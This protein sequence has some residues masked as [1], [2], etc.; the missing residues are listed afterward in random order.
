MRVAMIPALLTGLLA[1]GLGIGP[2]TAQIS[3]STW[4]EGGVRIGT[5]TTTC[6]AASEGAIRYNSVSAIIQYCDGASWDT[7]AG[8]FATGGI[9]RNLQ[10]NSAGAFSADADLMF[11]STSRLGVGTAVPEALLHVDGEILLGSTGLSCASAVEG[12]LRWNATD[13]RI[14]MC[15][16]VQWRLMVVTVPSVLLVVTPASS[17]AMDVAGTCGNATCYGSNVAFTVTNQGTVTSASITTSLTN[18]TN[19]EFVSDTCN[20]NTLAAAANC[21][22]TVRPKATAN[23]T[24]NGNL[25]ITANNN[26]IATLGGTASSFGCVV[27]AAGG[28]GIYAACSVGGLYDLIVQPGG[29]GGGTTNPTCAGGTDTYTRQGGSLTGVNSPV[30]YYIGSD[31]SGAQNT[32]DVMAYS[33]TGISSQAYTYCSDMVYGGYSDWY[34]PSTFEFRTYLYTNRVA[35]GGFAS[36]NYFG[37]Y[38]PSGT[39]DLVSAVDGTTGPFGCTTNSYIRCARRHNIALPS[40]VVDRT[41]AAF[42]LTTTY[43]TAANLVTSN[44]ITI[45]GV[46]ESVPVAAS[47]DG[48]PEFR[49]N[50][51]SW[52][53][54]GTVTNGDTVEVRATSGAV[55]TER[56]VTLTI[57][58]G[59]AGWRI[60]VPDTSITLRAFITSQTYNGA[61]SSGYLGMDTQ[62]N[63]RAAAANLPG[64]WMAL[65]GSHSTPV[66]DRMPWNWGRLDNMNGAQVAT[67]V[68]DLFDNSIGNAINRDENNSVRNADVW[69]GAMTWDGTPITSAN[70][71][72]NAWT[73]SSGGF[74]G[75]KGLSSSTTGTWVQNGNSACSTGV[76]LY[77]I[78]TGFGAT[79]EVPT[80]MTFNT[81]YTTASTVVSSNTVTL[82]GLNGSVPVTLTGGSAPD[83]R[84]NGG[85][86][87][88]SGTVTNGNTLQL[89]DTSG[90]AGTEQIVTARIGYHGSLWRVRVPATG[91]KRIFITSTTTNGNFGGI[92][93]A[94]AFCAA[95][96]NAV[97]LGTGW[98]ALVSDTATSFINVTPA[99]NW[100]TLN[101]MNGATVATSM[102]DLFDNS[103]ANA[104]NRDE[105]NTVRNATVWTA[106]DNTGFLYK[107][108]NENSCGDFGGSSGG[109]SAWTGT[110]SSTTGTAIRNNSQTCNGTYS[111]YC[112]E[113]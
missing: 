1:L 69:T 38:S 76:S 53:T 112:L 108:F 48:S 18:T 37:E 13:E 98:S 83:F 91:T 68:P 107:P 21:T 94:D 12:A 7:V 46:T 86:W 102:A 14:E 32:V 19:F 17:S 59:Q 40:P 23:G 30:A 77:C 82:A 2:A 27:G 84:I 51:G 42:S 85:S 16:G 72:C 105:S 41:P 26:P 6:D 52:V 103:I 87:V 62:C 61:F 73:S 74:V 100:T 11:S 93:G 4:G 99:W 92:K 89:R 60:R 54:S 35:I 63:T 70:G 67:S 31:T 39:C 55:G 34:V 15:D 43:T 28:G 104:I 24:Y 96:A 29:C 90:A 110:S 109:W 20:G 5:S 10:F 47:G 56:T 9:N 65:A 25:Q 8:S 88:T 50:G 113:N 97:G 64:T 111:L 45:S 33:G 75:Y 3:I 49:I 79:D 81:N 44:T 95:R 57:G 22:V 36:N 106:T 80:A 78:E 71:N 66:Y 58:S 101:N